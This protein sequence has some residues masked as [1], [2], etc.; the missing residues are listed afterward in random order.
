MEIE[1]TNPQPGDA[2]W[3]KLETACDEW[4]RD[5]ALPRWRRECNR[6]ADKLW[7]SGPVVLR[8]GVYLAGELQGVIGFCADV[9]GGWEVFL[10]GRR[11]ANAP[12]MLA[13]AYT[14][15]ERLRGQG[16]FTIETW[17]PS[18]NKGAKRVLAAGGLRATGAHIW[19][20][21]THGRPVVWEHWSMNYGR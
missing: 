9:A 18:L 10:A 6:L 7:Q 19:H 16:I 14:I 5:E 15:G 13:A 11:N 20:G 1:L 3:L 4:E 12:A 2:E 21:A 8:F 17:L